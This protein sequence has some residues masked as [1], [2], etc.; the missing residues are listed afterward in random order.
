MVVSQEFL[1]ILA[2]KKAVLNYYKNPTLPFKFMLNV[3]L[4]HFSTPI[5]VENDKEMM[6]IIQ[7]CLGTKLMGN[8]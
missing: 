2:N 6:N 5:D 1:R 8:W 4:F 7:S 3:S